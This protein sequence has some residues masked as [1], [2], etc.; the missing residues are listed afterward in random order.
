M[1]ILMT[2]LD[3]SFVETAAGIQQQVHNARQAL[4]R[5]QAEAEAEQL[6]LEA[7]GKGLDNM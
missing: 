2:F 3:L 7:R 5:R 4:D 6:V 1:F